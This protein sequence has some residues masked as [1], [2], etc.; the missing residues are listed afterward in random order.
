MNRIITMFI[1][2][3]L[4]STLA[5]SDSIQFEKANRL[6][7]EK[8]YTQAALIYEQIIS[9]Q[10]VAPELHYNLGNAYFRMNELGLSILNYERALRLNPLYKD[11]AYNLEFANSKVVDQVELNTTFFLKK[12]IAF[13]MRLLSP[14]NWFVLAIPLFVLAL[15]GALLF[16]FGPTRTIRKSSFY[17]AGFLMLLTVI[18][19]TFSVLRRNQLLNHSEAII[20]PGAIVIKAAPDKS[21]TDLF[22]LHEGTKVEVI[23]EL[24]EW[25]EIRLS[26]G[27]VG[28]IEQLHLARI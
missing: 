26:N 20:L 28:W 10:G 6:Y 3:L 4:T 5:A 21:G 8:Q 9:L 25:Y 15:A 7:T 1:F 14:D 11:A 27:N 19:I 2:V 13:L 17:I 12:W 24:G 16:I 18:S 23:S 22:Q